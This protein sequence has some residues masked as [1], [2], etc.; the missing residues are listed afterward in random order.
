MTKPEIAQRAKELL[1][2]GLRLEIAPEEI[3]DADPIFGSGLGLHSIHA[4]EFVLL[5]E[6][7]FGV[8]IPHDTLAK[9]VL[10]SI[11]ALAELIVTVQRLRTWLTRRA[12]ATDY[13]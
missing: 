7:N 3:V 9:P 5:I 1:V 6:E 11:N 10:P 2:T 13:D 4:L 8:S 12:G